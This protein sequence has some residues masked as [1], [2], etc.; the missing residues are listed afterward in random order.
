MGKKGG[1]AVGRPFG[2]ARAKGRS[3]GGLSLILGFVGLAGTLYVG[4]T[5]LYSSRFAPTPSERLTRESSPERRDARPRGRAERRERRGEAASSRRTAPAPAAAAKY[6]REWDA[7]PRDY[8][9]CLSL[10]DELMTIPVAWPGF[11]ALCIDAVSAGGPPVTSVGVVLHPRSGAPIL[12]NSTR[13][14]RAW[15]D[16]ASAHAQPVLTSLLEILHAE[17]HPHE[18]AMVDKMISTSAYDF[19]PNP[20]RL[21]TQRGHAVETDADLYA[22]GRGAA[23]WLY[24]GGQ[25][26]WPG[27]RLGHKYEVPIPIATKD[28]VAG[29]HKIV[30]LTT[31]SLR[32]VVLEL[33]GFLSDVTPKLSPP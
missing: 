2:S 5:L 15:D 24:T 33:S 30:E 31:R 7:L 22:L 23:L 25:F 3:R 8:D 4:T 16:G 20:W 27:V 12:K 9:E 14:M 29:A 26:L 11:H 10:Q 21:F 32:P 17:L 18:F 1:G 6:D 19:P 28:G 13:T